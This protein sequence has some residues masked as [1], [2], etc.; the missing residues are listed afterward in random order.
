M[1]KD[2]LII[3][4]TPSLSEKKYPDVSVPFQNVLIHLFMY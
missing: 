1:D 3:E 2:E 4:A